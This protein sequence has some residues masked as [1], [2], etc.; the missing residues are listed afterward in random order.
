MREIKSEYV[1][2][3]HRDKERQKDTKE[4]AEKENRYAEEEKE[5]Q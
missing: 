1:C 2:G 3:C 4:R 5:K